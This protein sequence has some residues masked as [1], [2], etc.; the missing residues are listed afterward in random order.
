VPAE[1]CKLHPRFDWVVRTLMHREPTAVLVMI[2]G[3]SPR[4]TEIIKRRLQV[5]KQLAH[6]VL[7][8]SHKHGFV[9]MIL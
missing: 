2:E 4:W 8:Y 3:Q 9:V 6:A 5:W 1:M 7:L